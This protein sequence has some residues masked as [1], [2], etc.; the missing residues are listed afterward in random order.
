MNDNI[1]LY[2]ALIQLYVR[3]YE[4][5]IKMD[6]NAINF[7]KKSFDRFNPLHLEL[8]F[9]FKEK[10]VVARNSMDRD[11]YYSIHHYYE[12]YLKNGKI[13]QFDALN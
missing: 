10:V 11:V 1:V 4:S 8:V 13:T 3:L 2:T 6:R 9:A 7:D 5:K 12:V